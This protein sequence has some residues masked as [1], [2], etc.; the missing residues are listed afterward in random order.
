MPKLRVRP[1]GGRFF[2]LLP[3][4]GSHAARLADGLRQ[5]G[6]M[7]GFQLKVERI[8]SPALVMTHA[9]E[10]GGYHPKDDRVGPMGMPSAPKTYDP[11]A[12][13]F[14]MRYSPKPGNLLSSVVRTDG[15]MFH[16]LDLRLTPWLDVHM[17]GQ[18]FGENTASVIAAEIRGKDN[19]T[20]FKV[21]LSLCV[22][23]LAHPPPH[24]PPPD[25]A[26][27]GIRDGVRASGVAQPHAWHCAQL[28]DHD[29]LV[30]LLR[31]CS[32]R[33]G[34]APQLVALHAHPARRHHH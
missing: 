20:S 17:A 10:L 1:V 14:S 33:V 34:V 5:D 23:W 28:R 13:E 11:A 30:I 24:T 22:W 31:G 9:I 21:C 12:Y 18:Y 27:S 32:L 26:T 8:V 29:L 2:S 16:G 15:F 25:G 4:A 7:V 19:V 6:L 3:V